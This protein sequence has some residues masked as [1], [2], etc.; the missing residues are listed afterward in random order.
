MRN[1][2]YE[3]DIDLHENETACRT[4]FHGFALRRVL[5]QVQENSEIAYLTNEINV[6]VLFFKFYGF[7]VWYFLVVKRVYV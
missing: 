4:H 1:L 6:R 2:S 7:S 5:K 3:N